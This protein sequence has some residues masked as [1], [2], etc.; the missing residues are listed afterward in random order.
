MQLY[1]YENTS[2]GVLL[3]YAIDEKIITSGLYLFKVNRKTGLR[4]DF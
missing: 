4:C 1:F 2:G 3:E